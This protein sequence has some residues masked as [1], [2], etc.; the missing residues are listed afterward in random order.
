[1]LPLDDIAAEN[2]KSV[3]TLHIKTL[4]YLVKTGGY[5][6][7]YP[8]MNKL[9]AKIKKQTV[10]ICKDDMKGSLA[11]L[12][13]KYTGEI[14]VVEKEAYDKALSG[15]EEVLLLVS[16]KSESM[17]SCLSVVSN[18]GVVYYSDLNHSVA[19]KDWDKEFL[20]RFFLRI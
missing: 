20:I 19:R 15:E 10:I 3:V 2:L 5:K 14:K 8:S 18:K 9:K 11:K 16:L 12:E 1:M 13:E 6:V 7:W 17:Y 4:N